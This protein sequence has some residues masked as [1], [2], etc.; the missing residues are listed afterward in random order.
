MTVLSLPPLARP[1][2][3]RPNPET[4]Q[5]FIRWKH[6]LRRALRQLC[7]LDFPRDVPAGQATDAGFRAVMAGLYQ[8]S[9]FTE[10]MA[11]QG[12]RQAG[13]A[14]ATGNALRTLQ[15]QLDAYDEPETDAAIVADPAWWVIL[16]QAMLVADLLG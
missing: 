3:P 5:D 4:S 1:E 16:G 8:E 14:N 11:C 9:R 13:L 15:Q 10:F 12:W 7:A 6:Q 2:G